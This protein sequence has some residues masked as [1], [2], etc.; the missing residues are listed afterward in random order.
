MAP[1][2]AGDTSVLDRYADMVVAGEVRRDPAQQ[3][4]AARLDAVA[5]GLEALEAHSGSVIASLF[6]R[7]RVAPEGLYIW[8][9]VGRGKTML[10]DLFFSSVQVT[11][12]RRVH[13][14]EFMN[15]VHEG[16]AKFRSENPG[17]RGARDPIP[18]VAR[19]ITRSVRLLCFD[20]FVVSDITDAMLLKRLFEILFADGVVVVATSNIPPERLYW[21]GLNRQLFLPFIDLLKTHTEVFNLDSET[22]YRRERLDAQDVYRIG[23]GAE[24]DEAMDALFAHLIGGADAQPMQVESLGRQIAVPAQA[25]G[26]AR[27]SFAELC[28]RPLGARDYLK[29]AKA[30]HT[31]VIDHVPVFSRLRSD[32]AKRFILLVDTLYDRGVKLA[33]SFE[34]PLD[35]LAQDDKTRFEFARCLSRLEE[36]RSAEYI[37]Q[38]LRQVAQ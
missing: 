37:A 12:K 6:K 7:K 34:A 18:A 20:E 9:D 33:A 17:T 1:R 2:T 38:P 26:V 32:A 4:A 19:P 21:N 29:L 36:M 3:E 25:M 28:E 31:I 23:T 22:D 24:I 15:E 16:I 5:R 35:A 8:G 14:H 11:A 10:M 27:F 30:F 13:F